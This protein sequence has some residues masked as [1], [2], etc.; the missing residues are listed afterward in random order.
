[1]ATVASVDTTDFLPPE[2]RRFAD[3]LLATGDIDAASLAAGCS[4]RT[5]HRWRSEPAVATY[6]ATVQERML[7][8]VTASLIAASGEAVALLRRTVGN[9]AATLSHRLRAAGTLLD[10]TLRWHE[11]RALSQRITALEQ[12]GGIDAQSN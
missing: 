6:L 10:A 11:L 1:M 2:K 8:Q 7:D 3:T 12:K 4:L 5:G 9:D